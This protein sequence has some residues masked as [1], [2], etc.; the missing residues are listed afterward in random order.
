[1]IHIWLDKGQVKNFEADGNILEIGADTCQ[2]VNI[3]YNELY[4]DDKNVAE[5]FKNG[6]IKEANG[7]LLWEVDKEEP[8]E[9]TSETMNEAVEM[10]KDII[11]DKKEGENSDDKNE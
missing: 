9:D 10:M 8:K 1:M 11:D 7:D 3:L 6:I 2:L 5:F 4:R